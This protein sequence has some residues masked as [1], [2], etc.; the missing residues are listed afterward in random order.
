MSLSFL[1]GADFN[2][3][4]VVSVV[5]TN[6]VTILKAI[7]PV[8]GEFEGVV[9]GANASAVFVDIP[10]NCTT[11]GQV[12]FAVNILLRPLDDEALDPANIN[13]FAKKT[14]APVT[15]EGLCGNYGTCVG[16]TCVCDAGFH[17]TF[18]RFRFDFDPPAVC[19]G[20]DITLNFAW[21]EEHWDHYGESVGPTGTDWWMIEHNEVEQN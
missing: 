3:S 19:P 14:C 21:L 15:C 9:D 16:T 5:P 7:E 13:I 4:F 2:A 17:G 12:V 20:E 8:F 1:W 10:F 6:D 18:C 11:H